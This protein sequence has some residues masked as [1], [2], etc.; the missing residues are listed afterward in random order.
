MSVYA[1]FVSMP[2]VCK[3]QNILSSKGD[4]ETEYISN[5]IVSLIAKHMSNQDKDLIST[6]LWHGVRNQP[7][8]DSSASIALNH[9]LQQVIL[10]ERS[11]EFYP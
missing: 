10:F 5:K 9:S 11:G 6:I 3:E 8:K 1:W 4:T 2:P 7:W